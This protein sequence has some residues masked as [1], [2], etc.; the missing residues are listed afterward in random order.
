M[1]RSLPKAPFEK[2][3]VQRGTDCV[4]ELDRISVARPS[5]AQGPTGDRDR[6]H[7]L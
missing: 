7:E 6:A 2:D 5:R 3:T 1:D 4:L